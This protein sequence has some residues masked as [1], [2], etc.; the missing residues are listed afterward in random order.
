M[1]ISPQDIQVQYDDPRTLQPESEARTRQAN[2]AAGMPLR[3]QLRQ[4]GWTPQ[5]L[6]QMDADAQE[7]A[8]ARQ[9][10]M[11]VGLM[12]QQ[13]FFDQGQGSA[14]PES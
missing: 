9:T 7:E 8:K 4:A 6:A 3:T 1:T 10:M 11:A 12:E 5:E 13:R 14:G 2:A